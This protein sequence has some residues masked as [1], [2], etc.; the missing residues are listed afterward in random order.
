MNKIISSIEWLETF[1]VNGVP[2]ADIGLL[3]MWLFIFLL[4]LGIQ[5]PLHPWKRRARGD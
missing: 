2:L 5:W 4:S 3:A 1:S